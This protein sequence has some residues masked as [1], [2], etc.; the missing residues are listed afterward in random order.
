[1]NYSG[2]VCSEHSNGHPIQTGRTTKTGNAHL[3][4]AIVGAAWA[5]RHKPWIGGWLAKRLQGLEEATK[6]IAWKDQ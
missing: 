2:L 5:C 6:A 4:R 3:R 1:M